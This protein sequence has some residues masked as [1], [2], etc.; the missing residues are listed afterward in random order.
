[1]ASQCLHTLPLGLRSIGGESMAKTSNGR[2]AGRRTDGGAWSRNTSVLATA[3]RE[4][5]GSGL[6]AEPPGDMAP[7]FGLDQPPEERDGKPADAML[8][9]GP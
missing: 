8:G 2:G 7:A 4:I 6:P 5:Y 9:V 3:L 1:M